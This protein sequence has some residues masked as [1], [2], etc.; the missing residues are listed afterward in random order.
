MILLECI[1]TN[2]SNI[3]DNKHKEIQFLEAKLD[4]LH[5]IQIQCDIEYV[6]IVNFAFACWQELVDTVGIDRFFYSVWYM[7]QQYP[8]SIQQLNMLNLV[9][10]IEPDAVKRANILLYISNLLESRKDKKLHFKNS[11]EYKNFH[12]F[13][14]NQD[15]YKRKRLELDTVILDNSNRFNVHTEVQHDSF[16]GNLFPSWSFF[17][18]L[19]IFLQE[20]LENKGDLFDLAK[21]R[22]E[23]KNHLETLIDQLQEQ[24]YLRRHPSSLSPLQSLLIQAN[25]HIP[26]KSLHDV[27]REVERLKAIERQ[28]MLSRGS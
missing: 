25:N 8:A 21:L 24:I 17:S 6:W 16:M 26:I 19:D 18:D 1:N 15:D 23:K 14:Y 20:L 9:K 12:C 13:T 27:V 4:E 5:S 10:I 28:M 11:E 22:I 2:M 3:Q 7:Y